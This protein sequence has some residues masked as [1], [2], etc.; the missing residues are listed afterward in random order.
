MQAIGGLIRGSQVGQII[1]KTNAKGDFVGWYARWYEGGVRKTKATKATSAAEARR[2]LA[3][4]E[5]RIGR[6]K[7]GV[8]DLAQ[9][10]TADEI[11][12]RYEPRY[13]PVP[14]KR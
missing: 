4:I 5:A 7:L 2:I 10:L 11:L 6:G 12:R 9:Q 3:E 1:R 8:P 14:P 13:K